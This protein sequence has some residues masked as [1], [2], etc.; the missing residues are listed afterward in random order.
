MGVKSAGQ[1]GDLLVELQIVLP[2]AMSEEQRT[3]A[4]SIVD[5]D[6][7]RSELVW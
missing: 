1:P 6:N 3:L 5:S 2:Q 7:P 4:E